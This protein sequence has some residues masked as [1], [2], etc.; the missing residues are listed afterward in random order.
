MPE[1]WR[2]VKGLEH[3]F[4]VSNTGRV[5]AVGRYVLNNGTPV[6]RDEH[7]IR[8]YTTNVGYIQ[9]SLYYD[10]ER[11]KRYAHRLVAEAFIPNP[12]GKTEVDHIDGNKLNNRMDNLQ[13]V[14]HAENMARVFEGRCQPVNTPNAKGKKG[15][16][17]SNFCACGSRK[18]A[19]AQMCLSCRQNQS[20]QHFPSF[21]ELRQCAVEC[22]CTLVRMGRYFGVSDHTVCKWLRNCGMPEKTEQL[23]EYLSIKDAS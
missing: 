7:I 5:K 23:K 21:D 10:G 22:D 17:Y 19:N 15:K 3:R 20:R 1:E 4:F 8:P 12:L 9:Y 18:S 2:P 14:T 16:S 11:Y 6:W 13:W